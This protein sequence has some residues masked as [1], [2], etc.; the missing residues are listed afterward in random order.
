M[1]TDSNRVTVAGQLRAFLAPVGTAAPADA[2]VALA[3]A[4]K[5]VGITTEDGTQ[6]QLSDPAFTDLRGHQSAYPV[7]TV[8]TGDSA[9][10]QANLMELSRTNLVGVMGGGTVTTVPAGAGT[11]YRYAPPA[12]G[13]RASVACLL[14]V[15]DGTKHYRWIV[16]RGFQRDGVTL[17]MEKGAAQILPLRLAVQGSD[18]GDPWYLLTDDP[19]FDP[20][21]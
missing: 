18:V 15:T 6:F 20:A 12:V 11:H 2:I 8:Q 7:R 14:E 16:P 4:W 13:G 19:A 5:E 17:N 10:V 9:Q 1:A 3:A 21:A